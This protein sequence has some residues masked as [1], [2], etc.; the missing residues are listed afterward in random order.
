MDSIKYLCERLATARIKEVDY[1][2]RNHIAFE[3]SKNEVIVFT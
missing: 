2:E 3:N 1:V